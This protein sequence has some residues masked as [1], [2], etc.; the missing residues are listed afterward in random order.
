MNE[1][2]SQGGKGSTGILTNKQAIARKF[3]VKQNE[4]V[5]FF[6]G[7]DLGGYKVIYDKSTQ[8]A[9]S[10]PVLPAGTTAISLN[11]HAVLVHSAGTVDLGELA[12]SREEYVTI[13][14]S[15]ALGGTIN[16]KNEQ[17]PFT[18]GN[19]RWEG[20]LPKSVPIGSTP[21]TSGGIGEGFWVNTN[22]SAKLTQFKEDLLE[23]DGVKH[24]GVC[25]DVATL[26]TIEP[27]FDGQRITVLGYYSTSPGQ[28][29]GDFVAFSSSDSDDGVN[30][31]VTSGGKRWKRV[32]SHIDIPVENGGMLA[33]RTAEQNSEALERIHAC[34]PQTGG[35]LRFSSFY[36]IKYGA[37]CPPRV[38]WEG[39]GRDSCG[40]RK[41]GN[42]IKTVPDRIWQGAPHSFS[43]DFI[44]AI[45]MDSS[46]SGDLTGNFSRSGSITG[47]GLIGASVAKNTYGIYSAISYMV[48]LEDLY[49][50]HVLAGYRT[51]DS[52]LQDFNSLIIKDVQDGIVVDTGGTTYNLTNVYV[53]NVTRWAYKFSNITYSSMRGC[54]A[55]FVTGSAYV[56]LG[57]T[58]VVMDGCGAEE[59]HGSLFECNQSRLAINAFRGV[60][61]MDT[62]ST[63]CI[64]TQCAVTFTGSFLPEFTG[65]PTSKY[66]QVNDTTINLINTVAPAASRVL[67]AAAVS[68]FNY[69]DWGGNYTIWGTDTWTATGY[70]INGV[71][72]VYGSSAPDSSVTQFGNGARWELLTP[73]A[74]QAYKWVHVGAGVWKVAG[75]VAA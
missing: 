73:I 61:L 17:L 75:S 72:H 11:E 49:I 7:V 35:K 18:D 10:L 55:D 66:W 29:G 32:G 16:T 63:A 4:V 71:A 41:T 53:K 1:M 69:S 5:Y 6:V 24:I 9:Y 56:F 54:A 34:L 37:I 65:S 22:P 26:R 39:V 44:A 62:G 48:R 59:I 40:L 45:D 51:S 50:E 70:K 28:G 57:C 15:F 43:L 36:D 23:P 64:F 21:S 12:L 60:N 47:M 30:I 14:G 19:Y 8:R 25:P 3:G 52:W 31:F 58:G 33:S 46:V 20:S 2:F 13:P 38:M 74:G 42:D 68:Q 27:S 67:W